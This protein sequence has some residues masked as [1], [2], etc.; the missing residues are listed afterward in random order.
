MYYPALYLKTALCFARFVLLL[1]TTNYKQIYFGVCFGLFRYF[2]L[3]FIWNVGKIA[4]LC[5]VKIKQII[6]IKIFIDL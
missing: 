4:Y 5:I 3:L 1:I 2:V 6:T